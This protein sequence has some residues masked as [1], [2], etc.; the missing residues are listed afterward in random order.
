[1]RVQCSAALLAAT[2]A[3][4]G[5]GCGGDEPLTRAEYVKQADAICTDYAA[6]QAKLGGPK[7]VGDIARVAE[8]TKPLIEERL[9]KL[10]ELKPPK[11]VED[12]AEEA[13]DLIERQLPKI[14]EL[15][16]AARAGDAARIR[17]IAASATKLDQQARAK[18]RAIGLKVCGASS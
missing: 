7:D 10:R 13:F 14:D 9:E 6:R 8:Q 16:D 3:L 15:E 4:A 5:S 17:S 2:V 18:T 12:S 11:A 1:M